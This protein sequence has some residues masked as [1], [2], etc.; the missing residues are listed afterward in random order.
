M[1]PVQYSGL[2]RLLHVSG[3]LVP[4]YDDSSVGTSD[5]DT[6][7]SLGT[8]V[9]GATSCSVIIISVPELSGCERYCRHSS[10]LPKPT[11]KMEGCF[12]SGPGAWLR[13]KRVLFETTTAISMFEP[14]EKKVFCILHTIYSYSY[15]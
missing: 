2:L 1:V 7:V 11:L 3:V 5:R 4:R 14:V 9:S 10:S 12:R 6:S 13:R 8:S 15:R